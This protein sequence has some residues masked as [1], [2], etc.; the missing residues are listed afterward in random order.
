MNNYLTKR[1]SAIPPVYF[2]RSVV[3]N[4]FD[5]RQRVFPEVTR[6]TDKVSRIELD[7]CEVKTVWGCG[8][9]FGLPRVGSFQ[10]V[11]HFFRGD[12]PSQ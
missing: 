6:G 5:G 4:L 8:H 12:P 3:W 1:F 2:N 9:D 7:V 11:L 10:H